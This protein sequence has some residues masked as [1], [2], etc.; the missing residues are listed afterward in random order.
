M[1]FDIKYSS[2]Q[3]PLL[4]AVTAKLLGVVVKFSTGK[5]NDAVPV[6]TDSDAGYGG[7]CS[8]AFTHLA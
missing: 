5:A 4:A 3:A 2:K 8:H 6:L 7:I 1:S